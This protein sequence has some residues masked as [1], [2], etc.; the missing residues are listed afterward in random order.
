[1]EISNPGSRY[2]TYPSPIIPTLDE[3]NMGGG[4]IRSTFLREAKLHA[5]SSDDS[6][7]III[8]GD[9]EHYRDEV[10]K[11]IVQPSE[12]IASAQLADLQEVWYDEYWALF[13]PD[14]YRMA[15]I[16]IPELLPTTCNPPAGSRKTA[17]G[18]DSTRF[19]DPTGWRKTS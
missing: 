14:A 7:L 4:G 19:P 13:Q 3:R 6:M 1:M 16:D 5:E 11:I 9:R 17:P 18:T 8:S 2:I 10:R 12:P 15:C